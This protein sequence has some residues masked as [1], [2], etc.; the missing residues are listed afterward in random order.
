MENKPSEYMIRTA[1]IMTALAEFIAEQECTF[2]V[3]AALDLFCEALRDL[4]LWTARADS[5]DGMLEREDRENRVKSRWRG[6]VEWAGASSGQAFSIYASVSDMKAGYPYGH[7]QSLASYFRKAAD[8]GLCPFSAAD[9]ENYFRQACA[10]RANLA[11]AVRADFAEF[12][13][14]PFG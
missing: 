12:S 5:A 4:G 7:P 3:G 1:T 2:P 13:E 14:L 8:S 6:L 11:Q 10:K 9:S